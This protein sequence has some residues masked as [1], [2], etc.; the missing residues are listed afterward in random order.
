[1][2]SNKGITMMALVITVIILIIL[3]S[4]TVSMIIGNQGLFDRTKDATNEVG[5]MQID[6]EINA[7]W[8]QLAIGRSFSSLSL[9]EKAEAFENEL[10]KF[11]SNA[12]VEITNYSKKEF[13]INYKGLE[14][15][16]I[17]QRNAIAS[18][19]AEEPEEGGNTNPNTDPTQH[20]DTVTIT[21]VSNGGTEIAS[22]TIPYG[23]TAE[24]PAKPKKAEYD[25]IK[26]YS[27]ETLETAFDFTKPVNKDTTLYARWYAI[28]DYYTYTVSNNVASITGFSPVGL[29][30]YNIGEY[31]DIEFPTSYSGNTVTQIASNAFQNKDKITSVTFNNTIKSIGSY[32]FSGCSNMEELTLTNSIT[33]LNSHA[34]QSCKKLKELYIPNSIQRTGNDSFNGCTGLTKVEVPCNLNYGYY[35]FYNC[36]SLEDIRVR[37]GNTTVMSDVTASTSSSETNSSYGIPWRFAKQGA[38]VTIE[39]GVTK[40]GREEFIASTNIKQIIIPQSVTEIGDSAFSNMTQMT[41][42]TR[43]TTGE[44]I[45]TIPDTVT[46]LGNYLFYNCSNLESFEVPKAMI[47]A[48]KIYEC[49]YYGT[50]ISSLDEVP[51]EIETIATRAFSHCLNLKNTVIP[52]GVKTIGYEAFGYCTNMETLTITSN[53]TNIGDRAFY[54]CTSLQQLNIP[55]N[56]QRTGVDSFYGCTGL[57]RVEVPCDMNFGQD[58]FDGCVNIENVLVR[59][60]NTTIIKDAV[61]S[62]SPFETN[63]TDG[64]PW[65]YAKEGALVTIEDGVTKI[66]RYCFYDSTKV[67][68]IIIP[69]SVTEIKNGAFEHMTQVTK[70]TRTATEELNVVT[71]PDTVTILEGYLFYGCSSLES[72]DIPKAMIDAKKINE[73]TFC[74]TKISTL[75]YIP[76]EIEKIES[77][78][79][80]NCMSIVNL[81]IPSGIKTIRYGAFSNCQNMETLTITSNVT[82][83]EERV[84]EKCTSLQQLNI[85]NNVQRV[86]L[87]SFNGCTGLTRVEFPCDMNFGQD[88]FDGCVNI[89]NVL[90]RVGNT[91]VITDAISS[92][93]PFE[94]NSS[95]GKPWRYA[96]EGAIVTIEDGVTVIGSN[97]FNRSTKVGKIIIPSSVTEIRYAAFSNMTQITK[98]TRTVTDEE[99]V[100]TIPDTVTTLGNSLF[101][102]CSNLETYEVPKAMIDAKK[103][104]D[105]TYQGTKISSLEYIPEEIETIGQ[106]AFSNCSNITE[107][108]LPS[109]IKTISYAAFRNCTAVTKVT[110]PGTVKNI[111]SN[112]FDQNTNLVELTIQEGVK[113][114][115]YEAFINCS[116][117]EEIKLPNSI[118]S[119]GKWSFQYCT[120]LKRVELPCDITEYQYKAFSGC[121]NI[122]KVTYKLGN[123]T[124]MKDLY[125][126]NDS[127]STATTYGTPWD[128]ASQGVSVKFENGITKIGNYAFYNASKVGSVV[129]PTSVTEIGNYVFYNCSDS[130]VINYR[131]TS[132]QWAAITKGTNN[133]KLSTLTINYNY[134]G[135]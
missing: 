109:N 99:N 63:S 54:Q 16:F 68:K 87:D 101:S 112:A 33:T 79:F 104:N 23:T 8:G 88:A 32:A 28:V 36:S 93:S 78:A 90:V 44:Y 30:R 58:A 128:E 50:K 121:T 37:V 11:D 108:S 6:E 4:I 98:H 41:S 84:F 61:A 15:I 34:F 125:P 105:Y 71:I 131:G 77:N 103:I 45:L 20:P 66:G 135:D 10:K 113:T 60:G 52:S 67:G 94:T 9:D 48:K 56:V 35:S 18:T 129:I 116:K 106:Y 17:A 134:S 13:T 111:P 55:N 7:M 43:N 65:K 132:E 122:E 42:Q 91:T 126:S 53:V 82:M 97:A 25:F 14:K 95:D 64:K 70:Q 118:T 89:E 40:I 119:I 24:K 85:P 130:L 26:W 21:F 49:T 57:T 62:T 127:N 100:I 75:E 120:G 110:I 51:I 133:D 114:I 83:I 115:G 19:V 5:I 92:T 81:V 72:Y 123:T 39:D 38:V 117:I 96:K 1:M 73:Y 76:E 69:S 107:I 2:R 74:R 29:E 80:A 27:E 124:V 12:T 3:A 59:V 46:T 102:G 86:G 47:D 22:Q 31:T